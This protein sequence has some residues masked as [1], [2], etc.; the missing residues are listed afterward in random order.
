MASTI[1][2]PPSPAGIP[3]AQ[4]SMPRSPASQWQQWVRV[5]VNEPGDA[6]SERLAWLAMAAGNR[7]IGRTRLECLALAAQWGAIAD[8]AR[9][10]DGTVYDDGEPHPVTAGLPDLPTPPPLAHRSVPRTRGAFGRDVLRARTTSEWVG[11][12]DYHRRRYERSGDQVHLALAV[13][14]DV[15]LRDAAEVTA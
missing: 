10:T 3:L 14:A 1:I 2:S 4:R 5:A 8:A 6:D 7:C 15:V 12:A 9:Q 11:R 13:R